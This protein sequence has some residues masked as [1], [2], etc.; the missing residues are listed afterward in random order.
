[1]SFQEATPVSDDKVT[2]E[3]SRALSI[4][5]DSSAGRLEGAN[6]EPGLILTKQEIKN[7]KR[8]EMVGLALPTQLKDVI[9]YLGYE[10]GAG[11]GLEAADFKNTFT[12]VH[13]HAATWN[14]LRVDLLSV[15]SNLQVFAGQMQVYGSSMEET[16]EEIK[17]L[18]TLDEYTIATLEDVKKLELELGDRFPGIDLGSADKKEVAEFAH[19]L[20]TILAHVK[21][22]E[23]DA[24]SIKERLDTFSYQLAN[25]VYPA[26]RLKI[27]GINNSTLRDEIKR[28]ANAIENRA[29][30]IGEKTK[31]YKEAVKQALGSA[32]SLNIVGIAT[33]IYIGVEAEKIRKERNKLRDQQ[34]R[35]VADMQTK[36]RILGSLNRVLLQLQDLDMIVIDADI[37]TKNLVTVWN[38]ITLFIDQSSKSVAEIDNAL[39]VRRFM[40]QFRLVIKPWQTIEK[41][42]QLLLDVFK[43][44]DEEFRKEYEQQ[45]QGVRK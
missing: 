4:M 22:R 10:T 9:A 44:A 13:E 17:A 28:L 5:F 38:K 32:A 45:E 20:D 21:E 6:R 35:D 25:T 41:D 27:A 7:I 29:I 15:G 30:A 11:R 3:A 36:D 42:A 24:N 8:Y 34:E 37:A 12:T 1:M 23:K 43:Q 33:S 40:T 26:I 14:P 18:R 19:Y 31:E 2:D 39:S 16:Y